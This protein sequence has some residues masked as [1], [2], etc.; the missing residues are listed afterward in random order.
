MKTIKTTFAVLFSV[1]L[2]M[3]GFS[4]K[5]ESTSKPKT[6]QE[7][8]LG[9]WNLMSEVTNDYHSGS[10][11]ITTYPFLPA[12]YMEFKNDGTVTD[13]EGGLT[14]TFG[15]GIID[16]SKIWIGFT[17]NIYD[18]KVLTGSDLQLYKKDV[19]GTDYYESTLNLKR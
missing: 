4:C 19:S 7:K 5:K 15:Y 1:I 10:S 17:T 13:Y 11:H 18:L 3:S 9:K 8:L 14:S 12:D 6:T 2:M 16:D